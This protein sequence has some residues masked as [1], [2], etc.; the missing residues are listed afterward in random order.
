MFL[1]P[2][3]PVVLPGLYNVWVGEVHL[4]SLLVNEVKKVLDGGRYFAVLRAE[5]D[6]EKGVDI[7]LQSFL[8]HNRKKTNERERER[9]SK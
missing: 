3:I 8:Q 6:M 4:R 7:R 9:E 5:N 2:S 1:P